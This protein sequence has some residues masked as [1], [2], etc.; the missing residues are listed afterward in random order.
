[1]NERY[2]FTLEQRVWL[3]TDNYKQSSDYKTIFEEFA[4]QFPNVPKP[5]RQKILN[6]PNK[7]QQMRSV[8]DTLRSGRPQMARKPENYKRVTQAT[9]EDRTHSGK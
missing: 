7:F 6:M 5:S 8:S 9:V 3:L 4:A 2:K 1:M